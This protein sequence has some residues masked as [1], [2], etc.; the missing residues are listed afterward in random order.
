MRPFSSLPVK[1]PV[2]QLVTE[3]DEERRAEW[4]L[5]GVT[6]PGFPFPVYRVVAVW[7]P[8]SPSGRTLGRQMGIQ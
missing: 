3:V 1:M 8:G 7:E 6:H 2:A 5:V 4:R